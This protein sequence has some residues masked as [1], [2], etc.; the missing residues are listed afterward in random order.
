MSNRSTQRGF[1]NADA[2]R[3]DNPTLLTGLLKCKCG[4]AMTLMSG[5]G[6]RYRY[7]RCTR[8]TNIGN[9]VCDTP[10]IPV[11][12]MDT[13][14]LKTLKDKIFNPERIRNIL[15]ELQKALSGEKVDSDSLRRKLTK[16]LSDVKAQLSRLCMLFEQD[17]LP[18]E[19]LKERSD[20]GA[21]P[22]FTLK[23]AIC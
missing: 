21:N 8:R 20:I 10:N 18:L 9:D 17:A 15:T 6:G 16:E 14:I 12:E 5:K 4:A 19:T 2:K 23:S 3:K 11:D 22:T 13:L 1:N 7:Y